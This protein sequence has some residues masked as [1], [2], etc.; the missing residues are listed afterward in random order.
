MHI[1]AAIPRLVARIAL[2]L[3]ILSAIAAVAAAINSH[4]IED[5]VGLDPD[6]GSGAAELGMVVAFAAAALVLLGIAITA[7]LATRSVQA[8]EVQPG[9]ADSG[10]ARP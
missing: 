8:A 5:V 7:I 9:A 10:G 6:G 3:G 1:F 4:W 2:V